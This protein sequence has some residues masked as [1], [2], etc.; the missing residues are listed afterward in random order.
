[1]KQLLIF[2]ST[3]SVGQNALAVVRQNRRSFAVK[4]LCARSDI[5]TLRAQVEE[6]G[7]RYVCV[8]DEMAAAQLKPALDKRIRLFAGEKGLEEFCAVS[9]DISLMAISGISCLKPLLLHMRHARRIALANKESI[10]TAGELVF[11]KAKLCRTE[12]LPVDSEINA[13]YQLMGSKESLVSSNGFSK[14][15]LTASGGSL[16]GYTKQALKRARVEDVLRHPTWKMGQRITVD[17]ATL[18]NK[19]FE[20]IETHHFFKLPYDRID[21]VIHK[22]SRIHALVAFSDGTLFACLY[23][24][25]MKIPIAFSF[26]YPERCPK[27]MY[28]AQRRD[29]VDLPQQGVTYTFSPLVGRK[30]PLLGLIVEAARRNDNA[31]VVLNACDEVAIDY[32]LKR[33]IPFTGIARALER[34]FEH[35]P[36]SCI[37]TVQDVFSWDSWARE[38]TKEYLEKL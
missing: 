9:S 38:K 10:V 13:L 6:F 24:P 3:G 37:R 18:V 16:A 8:C 4:G 14:V 19:G 15:Y 2:G 29:W 17:S 21:V 27:E 20:V 26:Y 33:R 35:Y 23:P 32:F 25:D 1:M 5:K 36:H 7:P 28:E 22:E 34:M 12:I 11:A 31:L 30:Y